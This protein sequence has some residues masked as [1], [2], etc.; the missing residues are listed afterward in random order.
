MDCGSQIKYIYLLRADRIFVYYITFVILSNL[1]KGQYEFRAW[2]GLE[3][4]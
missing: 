3:G 1:N 2:E 4:R